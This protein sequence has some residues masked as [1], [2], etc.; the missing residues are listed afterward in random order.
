MLRYSL[1]LDERESQKRKLGYPVTVFLSQSGKYK[2]VNLKLF[3]EKKEWDFEK[4]LPKN[5]KSDLLFIK[6]KILQLD[7]FVLDSQYG[8]VSSLDEIKNKL[9]GFETVKVDYSFYGFCE[10][11]LKQLEDKGKESSKEIINTAVEQLKLYR[12]ELAWGDLNYTFFDGFKT[13]RFKLGNSKN[14]IH[15]YLR[16][17]RAIYNE[18][19]KRKII[20]DMQPFKDVMSDVYVKPNR[21]KKR[22]LSKESIVVLE[23]LKGLNFADQR[24]LDLWLLMFYF[25]GQDLKDVYYLKNSQIANGRVIFR[26]GKLDEDGYEFDLKLFPKISERLNKYKEPGEYVFPW[27]KSYNGYKT[28]RDNFRRSMLRIIENYNSQEEIDEEDKLKVLPAGGN[29]TIKVARHTFSNL[30]KRLYVEPDLLRELMGHERN[31]VDTIYKD[32]FPEEDRDKWHW[33]IINV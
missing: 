7:G 11:Y 2:K 4:H 26:R 14:T 15:T 10:L 20:E 13:W 31:D 28:F 17:Y 1:K 19:V 9:L 24:S 25:G 33:K 5:S 27:R 30:G 3:F 29:V 32:F 18:A 12:P 6:K 22:Y 23:S 8:I 21:T 16:K